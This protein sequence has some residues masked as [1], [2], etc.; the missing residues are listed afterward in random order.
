[1]IMKTVTK[2]ISHTILALILVLSLS[3]P[4]LANPDA[5]SFNDV[6]ETH[7]SY[8][9]V[10]RAFANE[11]VNGIGNGQYTPDKS[12]SNAEWSQMLSNLFKEEGTF[13]S[14]NVSWWYNAV[15][16]C[17]EMS[18]LENTTLRAK[19]NTQNTDYMYTDADVNTAINRFD[20]AQ[21]IYNIA[22]QD[23]MFTLTVDTTGISSKIGDYSKIPSNYRI[24]VEYCYAAGFITGVDQQGTFDGTGLMTRG[25]AATVLCRLLD[26]KNGDWTV[27]NIAGSIPTE[28]PEPPSGG[29]VAD[30]LTTE[31]ML[32]SEF[33]DAVRDE[34]YILINAHRAENGKRELEANTELQVYA[35]LRAEELFTLFGHTRPD[36]TA[37]GSGWYNSSNF[38]NSRYAENAAYFRAFSCDRA[39][40]IAEAL[41]DMWEASFGHNRHML[42][43]FNA[44]I[45]MALGLSIIV[46]GD[47]VI[48]FCAIFASGY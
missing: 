6:P 20:M 22:T 10:E 19:Y 30:T 13:T 12:V 41:F 21:M 18:W 48:S 44:E 42:Y 9:F 28:Q 38:M 14:P 2:R 45:T 3:V 39:E 24:A 27:P 23:M 36:G 47:G 25:A 4:A 5:P 32:S 31:Y 34:F 17:H 7:W 40:D 35:D 33:A 29:D 1:M 11:L 46:L 26:A 37:A 15:R 43:D 16:F 8:D